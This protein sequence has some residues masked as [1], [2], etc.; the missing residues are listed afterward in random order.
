[1]EFQRTFPAF[2]AAVGILLPAAV[3]AQEQPEAV[4]RKF[5]DATIAGNFAELR[6]WG[7]AA[8]GNELAAAPKEER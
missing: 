8:I 3:V 1:M 5:H 6:K 4:Y 2:V 7:T